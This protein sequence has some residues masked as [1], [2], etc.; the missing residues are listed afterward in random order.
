MCNSCGNVVTSGWISVLN[1]STGLFNKLS[2]LSLPMDKLGLMRFLSAGI[3]RNYPQQI[4]AIS[5][6]FEQ[7]LY[8]V[9]TTPITMK[10]N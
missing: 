3:A 5:P 8:P 6:L 9:S 1:Q 10:K 4:S 7:L 2:V